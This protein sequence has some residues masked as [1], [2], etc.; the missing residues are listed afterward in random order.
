MSQPHPRPL[1]EWLSPC[2]VWGEAA[3]PLSFP[4]MEPWG[5]LVTDA[6]GRLGV[7]LAQRW[8]ALQGRKELQGC[9]HLSGR[10][11]WAAQWR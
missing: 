11:T 8:C 9:L 7:L 1:R 2:F 6:I 10:E 5:T 3:G 4:G